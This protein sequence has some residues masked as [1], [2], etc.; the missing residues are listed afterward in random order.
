MV[1]LKVWTEINETESEEKILRALRNLFPTLK[2][3]KERGKIEGEG[4]KIDL[5]YLRE[6][7]WAKRILDT[8]RSQLLRGGMRLMLNKQAAYAGKIAVVEDPDESPL[9]P[10]YVEIETHNPEEF[11]DWFSPK[12]KNGKPILKSQQAQD[13]R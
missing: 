4:K 1:K 13:H 2:F 9:G 8:V 6:R 7:I 10:I 5:E 3:R 11:L 12:T